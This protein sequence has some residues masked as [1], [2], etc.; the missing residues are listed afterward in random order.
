VIGMNAS[1]AVIGVSRVNIKKRWLVSP[2]LF[3]D[4]VPAPQAFAKPTEV[5]AT[6][7]VIFSKPLKQLQGKIAHKYEQLVKPSAAPISTQQHS[8]CLRTRYTH[9]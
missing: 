7:G 3:A 2:F 9:K 6:M 4:P 8:L 1:C 5:A